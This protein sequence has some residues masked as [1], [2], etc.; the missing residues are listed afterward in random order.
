MVAIVRELT[1]G[2]SSWKHVSKIYKHE[3]TN[4]KTEIFSPVVTVMKGNEGAGR[5]QP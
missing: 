3:E 1:Y 4:K 5:V 2:P